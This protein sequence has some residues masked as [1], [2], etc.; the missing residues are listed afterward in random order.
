MALRIRLMRMGKKHETSFRIVVK[1]A[2]S[3]RDGKYLEQV[4]FYNPKPKDE[5]V[6]L[7]EE[8]IA[9]WLKVGAKPTETVERLIKKYT[10]LLKDDGRA[11]GTKPEPATASSASSVAE[12]GE[13][14]VSQQINP[15]EV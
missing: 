8:R 4:G 3:P 12:A 11:I 1:E 13:N 14:S 9:H 10:G 5:Q 7:N 6:R 15:E 2:R